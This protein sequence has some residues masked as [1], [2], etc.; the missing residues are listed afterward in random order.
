[1]LQAAPGMPGQ[2]RVLGK[3]SVR[4]VNCAPEQPR[5]GMPGQGRVV[6]KSVSEAPWRIVRG[7]TSF[8]AQPTATPDETKNT[9][10]WAPLGVIHGTLFERRAVY[11]S[12]E[13]VRDVHLEGPGHQ[14]MLQKSSKLI[15][16]EHQSN[17]TQCSGVWA[18]RNANRKDAEFTPNGCQVVQLQGS[19][20]PKTLTGK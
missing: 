4:G 10:L 20:Q 13:I 6:E 3:I 2:G 14:K 1:M 17:N 19:G 5:P 9:I 7:I 15:K 12:A 16:M 11:V 18:C 8:C